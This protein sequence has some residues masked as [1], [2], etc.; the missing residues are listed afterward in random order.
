[1][2]ED[3]R[4]NGGGM[5]DRKMNGPIEHESVLHQLHSLQSVILHE[6]PQEQQRIL[7]L[8]L[9]MVGEWKNGSEEEIHTGSWTGQGAG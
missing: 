9:G 1:M 5:G 7:G 4:S 6:L 3:R 2:D 8:H